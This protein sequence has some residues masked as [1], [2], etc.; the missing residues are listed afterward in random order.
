MVFSRLKDW[1]AAIKR[2]V[3]V[4]WLAA[5]DDRVPWI[6]K[7]LAGFVAIYAL[8]PIDLIPDFLPVIGY[9]DDLL[10]VPLGILLVIRLIP[11]DV[12]AD[13]REQAAS[14]KV[15]AN[16]AFGILIVITIWL[17]AGLGIAWCLWP[18]Q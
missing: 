3:I 6:A 7:A 15:N 10:I 13:L 4:L 9:F 16:G 12:L 8:S 18:K 2:D 1:A 17:L 11:P 5:R 14:A